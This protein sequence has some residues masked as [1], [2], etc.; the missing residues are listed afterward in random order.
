MQDLKFTS[1]FGGQWAPSWKFK[2]ISLLNLLAVISEKICKAT[3]PINPLNLSICRISYLGNLKLKVHRSDFIR[4]NSEVVWKVSVKTFYNFVYFLS[5]LK[6]RST[7][8]VLLFYQTTAYKIF[9]S[10]FLAA[11]N[12]MKIMTKKKKHCAIKGYEPNMI[13]GNRK[14][15]WTNFL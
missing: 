12:A 1:D 15:C 7:N 9:S 13:C 2:K 14:V 8:R 4:L 6:R 3:I 11:V 5:I 10:V